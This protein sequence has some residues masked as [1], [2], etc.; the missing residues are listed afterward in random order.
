[1]S[2]LNWSYAALLAASA[3]GAMLFFGFAFRSK[4]RFPINLVKLHVVLA[5][6]AWLLLTAAI[7]E[8]A[9]HGGLAQPSFDFVFAGT[10][11]VVFL[12]AYLSGLL[13]FLKFD[14][15][16]RRLRLRFVAAH[17]ILA[18][19]AFIMVTSSVALYDAPRSPRATV[20]A[21]LTSGASWYAFFKHR[22]DRTRSGP[23]P[24]PPG[25]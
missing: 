25:A 7:V 1:M 22:Y 12:L 8:F 16:R 2:L 15:H 19:L 10:S 11:Y 6:L 5:S 17:L 9:V 4:V 18:A 21:A 14:L 3:A 24:L 20:R 13:F 23:R